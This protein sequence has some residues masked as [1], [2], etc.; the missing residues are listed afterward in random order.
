MRRL[1]PIVCAVLLAFP[2]M[3]GQQ[4]NVPFNPRGAAI[5][6]S[7]SAPTFTESESFDG[8]NSGN[9]DTF[10]TVDITGFIEEDSLTTTHCS[11]TTQAHTGGAMQAECDNPSCYLVHGLS[12]FSSAYSQVS[13]WIHIESNSGG[14]PMDTNVEYRL[15]SSAITCQL[16]EEAGTWQVLDDGGYT[17]TGV[18]F[19][20]G[21]T[22]A[23]LLERKEG[24]TDAYCKGCAMLLPLAS[25]TWTGCATG[26]TTNETGDHNKVRLNTG[27]NNSIAVFDEYR[28][29]NGQPT[30]STNTLS[31]CEYQ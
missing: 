11:Y 26:S 20:Q 17:D 3:V 9:C 18:T 13:V 25:E 19:A 6:T 22:Y 1:F 8:S 28:Y 12:A 23:L 14:G 7:Y 30:D 5:C 31:P 15:G 29:I 2:F 24:S 16:R 4:Y 10:D 27:E 21:N